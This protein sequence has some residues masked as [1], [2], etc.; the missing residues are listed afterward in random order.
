MNIIKSLIKKVLLILFLFAFNYSN[1]QVSVKGYRKSNGTYVQPHMRSSPDGNPYNNYSFPGN[2]NPYT[3][4]VAGGN[5]DTYLKRYNKN[6]QGSN[7]GSGYGY[8]NNDLFLD[9]GYQATTISKAGGYL[10]I[11]NGTNEKDWFFGSEFGDGGDKTIYNGESTF[12]FYMTG[13]I[14]VNKIYFGLGA[15]SYSDN[16]NYYEDIN[17]VLWTGG[18]YNWKNH[19]SYK[20]GVMYSEHTSINLSL[21]LGYKFY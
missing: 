17:E 2:V 21:G 19:L 13:L 12:N 11:G 5:P 15:L 3:G 10:L 9:I 4:K 16:Y 6:Y 7:Y 1:A 20:F 18:Y 8:Y 14:G